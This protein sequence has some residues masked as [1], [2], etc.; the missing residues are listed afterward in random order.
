MTTQP[1]AGRGAIRALLVGYG[2]AGRAFHAPF[3][4]TVDGLALAGIVASDSGRRSQAVGDH[5]EATLFD[6]VDE[7]LA[8]AD[9]FDV[10]VVAAPNRAHVP[11]ASAA[12]DAGLAV[13]V[14]KPLAATA[15]EARGLIARA[16]DAGRML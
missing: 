10:V 4:A 6:S 1:Q 16:A 11:V 2:L 9:R 7:A 12:L 14:D 8:Q 13:V 5:P 15:A 3:L